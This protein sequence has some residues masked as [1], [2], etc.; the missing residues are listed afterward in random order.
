M[1]IVA[2]TSFLIAYSIKEDI[3]HKKAIE[4]FEKTK[5]IYIPTIAIHELVWFARRKN[6]PKDIIL[7]WILCEKTEIIE[8]TE[9]DILFA[10]RN[11][12]NLSDYNDF[13]IISVALRLNKELITFD[14]KQEKYYKQFK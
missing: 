13:V 7:S 2:D 10:L 3:H 9:S 5:L 4:I 12:K 1:E 14:E 11:A 8:I 6:L